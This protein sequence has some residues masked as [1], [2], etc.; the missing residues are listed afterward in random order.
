MITIEYSH[1]HYPTITTTTTTTTTTGTSDIAVSE[2]VAVLLELAGSAGSSG[3]VVRLYD[4]GVAGLHR[5][6]SHLD[7]LEEADC[8]IVIAG[9]W[10]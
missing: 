4:V 7:E 3:S 5:L 8:I 1:Y 2:E 10:C 6:L 9:R